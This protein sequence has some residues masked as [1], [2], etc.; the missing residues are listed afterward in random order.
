MAEVRLDNVTKRWGDFV[1]VHQMSLDIQDREHTRLIQQLPRQHCLICVGQMN[2]AA[3]VRVADV[4]DPFDSRG[5]SPEWRDRLVQ[6]F[7]TFV[8]DSQPYFF[9]R[10]DLSRMESQSLNNDA[11]PEIPEID[12]P[13]TV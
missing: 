10:T 6:S 13:F 4:A 2:V 7:K 8:Y 1:G 11:V 12:G 5:V 9:E 3:V